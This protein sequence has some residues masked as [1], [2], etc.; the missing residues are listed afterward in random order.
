VTL[1]ASFLAPIF[2]EWVLLQG[3]I[4]ANRKT[5]L[6]TLQEQSV[7]LVPGGAKEALYAH[8][9]TLKLV[10]KDRMGFI[11]LAMDS[12]VSVIPCIGFGENEIFDTLSMAAELDHKDE[13]LLWRI[14]HTVKDFLS[15][16]TPILKHPIPY[17][18]QV[19]VV[20]G[21]PLKLHESK[22]VEENHALYLQHLSNVYERNKSK[23]G[24]DKV[25]LEFI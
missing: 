11:K 25:K 6:K 19:T 12:N 16:S 3:F 21:E 20:V 23:Y 24:Y 22:S 17:R 1:N 5:L 8:P 13:K 2:R 10:L 15:F 7:V 14:Q 18:T 4:S 9:G